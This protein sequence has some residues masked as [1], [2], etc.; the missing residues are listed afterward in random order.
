MY[1]Q[2][3]SRS[4][5]SREHLSLTLSF[6]YFSFSISIPCCD[7]F[8]TI[9]PFLSLFLLF[10]AALRVI[11]PLHFASQLC[12][13]PAEKISKGSYTQLHFH[14]WEA[15]R[16]FGQRPFRLVKWQEEKSS[17]MFQ[18]LTRM[19]HSRLLLWEKLFASTRPVL[20]PQVSVLFLDLEHMTLVWLS[21]DT[22]EGFWAGYTI[23]WRT[24]SFLSS[25]RWNC[26]IQNDNF[27]FWLRIK[28]ILYTIKL[29]SKPT[30][31]FFYFESNTA[32]Q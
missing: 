24:D 5:G 8:Y 21:P 32:F 1:Y 15:R 31:T 22:W 13:D 17:N 30:N 26:I 25:C 16:M 9:L 18:S 27:L 2:I 28:E 6:C 20:T 12:T 29:F 4:Q 11:P 19:F 23:F 10:C 14:H 3:L 7:I